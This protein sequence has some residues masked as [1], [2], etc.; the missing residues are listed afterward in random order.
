MKAILLNNLHVEGL[1]LDNEIIAGRDDLQENVVN[2]YENSLKKFDSMKSRKSDAVVGININSTTLE[3]S[4]FE[5]EPT[6]LEKSNN[7]ESTARRH[8]NEAIKKNAPLFSARRE[9]SSPEISLSL[10]APVK[11]SVIAQV[12]QELAQA[13]QGKNDND[14]I[15]NYEEDFE[16][17]EDIKTEL[18][19]EDDEVPRATIFPLDEVNTLFCFSPQ[20]KIRIFFANIIGTPLVFSFHL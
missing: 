19:K 9:F 4:C 15:F 2:D 18:A 1:E 8:L 10:T 20:N 13:I 11:L 6:F 17:T 12:T 14:E 5:I 3:K 16:Y 7:D